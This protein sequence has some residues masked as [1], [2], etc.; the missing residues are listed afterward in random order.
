MSLSWVI[1]LLGMLSMVGCSTFH[2]FSSEK[3]ED[4]NALT[5][6]DQYRND[7]GGNDSWTS[8]GNTSSNDRSTASVSSDREDSPYYKQKDEALDP[9]DA[10][11]R[12]QIEV[13]RG[14]AVSSY[15]QGDRA[16]RNDF[17]DRSTGDGSLWSNENDANY[18][19]TK[20]K[21]RTGGDI[22]SVKME[23]PIL[24]Q[25]AEEIKKSLTPAEQEVE[26]ALYRKNSA[27]AKDD[28][29]LSAYRNVAS[30]DLKTS[31]AEEVKER[32]EKSVRWSQVD[33]SK[34]IGIA[35]NEEMRAEIID[36]YPNGNYKI[37]AVKR[38]IYRG[39]SKMMSLVAVAPA[40]DFD[41]KDLIASGKLY[42][43]KIKVAR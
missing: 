16:T 42:E 38:V 14:L 39:S 12:Q 2:P 8:N 41:E 17:Y 4:L 13:N 9:T 21:V 6:G 3:P 10:N 43:Y 37:R 31:E 36:R 27:D 28:K 32:M 23:E 35:P 19:F 34:A 11:V 7:R 40:A 33:L 24:R 30:E 25:L 26:M 22:I 18:F 1:V 20:G 5:Y 15:Q 29:D